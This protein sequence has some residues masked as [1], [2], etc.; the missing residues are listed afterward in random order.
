MRFSITAALI[1]IMAPLAFAL[2]SAST[3]TSIE[4]PDVE[5]VSS[6]HNLTERT[7]YPVVWTSLRCDRISGYY[8]F[9][10]FAVRYDF[11]CLCYNDV[12]TFCRV[13][14]LSYSMNT[15]IKAQ[16]KYQSYNNYPTGKSLSL[17]INPS[18]LDADSNQSSRFAT[19][20]RRQ[21]WIHL[22]LWLQRRQELRSACC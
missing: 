6:V 19:H 12:D 15:W 9:G 8:G 13:N 10:I 7:L 20:L 1:A 21:G 17:R 11:G 5:L 22:P 18:E 14:S 2:P 3:S 4:H 16:F